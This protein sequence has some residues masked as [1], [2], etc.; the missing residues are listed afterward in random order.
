MDRIKE[1]MEML[2][3]LKDAAEPF[4]IPDNPYC[5]LVKDVKCEDSFTFVIDEAIALL[6]EFRE[7]KTQQKVLIKTKDKKKIDKLKDL[8][9]SSRGLCVASDVEIVPLNAIKKST[10][11]SSDN[12][13]VM[14]QAASGGI[15]AIVFEEI[16][17]CSSRWAM[18]LTP[19]EARK[20][21]QD[22]INMFG[23]A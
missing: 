22:M 18:K 21:T 16:G 10:Y 17:S 8:L 1:T 23:G 4:Q 11:L 9:S 5:T 12:V 13:D 19:T 20:M 7:V 15:Y 6:N 3:C 14:L 2:Q